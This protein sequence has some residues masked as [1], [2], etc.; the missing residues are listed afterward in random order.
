MSFPQQIYLL[1]DYKIHKNDDDINKKLD[2][3]EKNLKEN[4]YYFAL[5][6][7]ED[8]ILQDGTNEKYNY[9]FLSMILDHYDDIINQ[10]QSI[11]PEMQLNE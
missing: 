11:K 10:I 9:K 8:L 4:Q 3:V 5:L 1:S 7:L 6:E 2:N